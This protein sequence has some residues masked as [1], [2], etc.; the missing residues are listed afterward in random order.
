[1]FCTQCGVKNNDNSK[2]C[3]KCGK[4]LI[5]ET[6]DNGIVSNIENTSTGL[7]NSCYEIVFKGAPNKFKYSYVFKN[8]NNLPII[9]ANSEI[10]V[11]T[12]PEFKYTFDEEGN[13][14]IMFSRARYEDVKEEDMEYIK[15]SYTFQNL[16]NMDDKHIA[17]VVLLDILKIKILIK[18]SVGNKIFLEEDCKGILK[19]TGK[20]LR[21]CIS[22]HG[23]LS[24]IDERAGN[25]LIKK[26]GI[27]IGIIQSERGPLNNTYIIKNCG[28][29]RKEINLEL[30]VAALVTKAYYVK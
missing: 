11:I 22:S 23:I 1:M 19:N 26:N 4:N 10:A 12:C 29:L 15:N 18:D 5:S 16:F 14:P 2:F 24:L 6:C 20:I 28:D 21:S 30:I 17:T 25:L 13:H 8:E 3:F 9:Y 7:L 27:I